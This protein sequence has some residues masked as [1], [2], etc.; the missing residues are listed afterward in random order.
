[1]NDLLSELAGNS[2]WQVLYGGKS[3]RKKDEEIILRFLALYYSLDTYE[4][5]MKK[6]LNNFMENNR[7]PD[8]V[9]CAEFRNKFEETVKVVADI[10]TPKALRPQRSLNVSVVDAVLVGLAHRL[11]SGPICDHDSLKEAHAALLDQMRDEELYT[12]GTTD[13]ER[14]NRRIELARHHYGSV[15]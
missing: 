11:E 5:P 6:F 9:Q 8:R 13:R 2:Y 3:N 7:K 10:I 4:R 1:M 12:S 15:G 14:V